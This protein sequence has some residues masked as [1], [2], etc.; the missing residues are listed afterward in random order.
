M[1]VRHRPDVPAGAIA[2]A[3]LNGEATVKRIYKT[4]TGYRLQPANDAFRPIEVAQPKPG[5]E[6]G[7][8]FSIAGPVV[9]VVRTKMQ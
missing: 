4:R 5:E 8:D 1:V 3:C 6:A 7:T 9:G 2:V